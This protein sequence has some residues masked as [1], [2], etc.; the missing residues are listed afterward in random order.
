MSWKVQL[1]ALH[2][3]HLGRNW[4]QACLDRPVQVGI[5]ATS[6]II[7]AANDWPLHEW[8]RRSVIGDSRVPG[9]GQCPDI[10]SSVLGTI[11]IAVGCAV[12]RAKHIVLSRITV[13]QMT[14]VRL[15]VPRV[16]SHV[17]LQ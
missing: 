2:N 12:L 9:H 10:T 17:E 8:W 15:G 1:C 13:I 11:D 6:T 7:A 3:E 14:E 4:V 5:V 16:A